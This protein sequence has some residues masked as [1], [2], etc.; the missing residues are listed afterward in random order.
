ME[1]LPSQ[2]VD[3]DYQLGDM[4]CT[5]TD[6]DRQAYMLRMA[7]EIVAITLCSWICVWLISRN[8]YG[9]G[10]Q[11]EA[12]RL[13][14]GSL[15]RAA[16]EE[17]DLRS[18]VETWQEKAGVAELDNIRLTKLADGYE[19]RA[20]TAEDCLADMQDAKMELMDEVALKTSEIAEA[21][22]KQ[23]Y[24]EAFSKEQAERIAEITIKLTAAQVESGQSQDKV[25]QLQAERVIISTKLGKI[26]SGKKI[27]QVVEVRSLLA[28]AEQDIAHQR[29]KVS[30]LEKD[31]Q[32]VLQKADSLMGHAKQQSDTF[33]QLLERLQVAERQIEMYRAKIQILERWVEEMARDR[34]LDQA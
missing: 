14:E 33:N 2:D 13:L 15:R 18:R 8:E 21:Q 31:Q 28:A 34:A 20:K 17:A 7:L 22:K 1:E 10:E 9:G 3:Y 26:V 24:L 11:T 6:S 19:L 30:D 5:S 32:S 23:E 27:P 4:A 12:L 29:Q 25:E 16:V